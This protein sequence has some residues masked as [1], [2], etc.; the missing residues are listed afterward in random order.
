[1][2]LKITIET[3]KQELVEKILDLLKGESA[4]IKLESAQQIESKNIGDLLDQLSKNH[5]IKSIKD[6]VSWQQEIREERALP[7]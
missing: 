3:N 4:S 1:M 2:D 7:F 6:P 5:P